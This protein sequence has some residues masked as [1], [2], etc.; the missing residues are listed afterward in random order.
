MEYSLP[1]LLEYKK[2]LASVISQ[3]PFAH[4]SA[5]AQYFEFMHKLWNLDDIDV[6]KAAV[7]NRRLEQIFQLDQD[8]KE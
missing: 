8:I 5:V 6:A 3:F 4:D 1:K 7:I 2:K